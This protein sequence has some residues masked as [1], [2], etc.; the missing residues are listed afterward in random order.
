MCDRG[1]TSL[2]ELILLLLS[3]LLEE[4]CWCCWKEFAGVVAAAV[5]VF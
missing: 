1:K 2:L 3:V 5:V 4:V